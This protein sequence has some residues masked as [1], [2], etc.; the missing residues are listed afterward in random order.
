MS[1]CVSSSTIQHLPSQFAQNRGIQ[2]KLTSDTVPP[3]SIPPTYEL[4]FGAM[5]SPN[6]VG[7]YL[8]VVVKL[9][10][11]LFFAQFPRPDLLLFFACPPLFV[12][13]YKW[14]TQRTVQ[15]P[16]HTDE[17]NYTKL[18]ATRVVN[19]SPYKSL[20]LWSSKDNGPKFR[21]PGQKNK[22]QPTYRLDQVVA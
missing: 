7:K 18:P 8:H 1:M 3:L 4:I 9:S 16:V 20:S 22:S 5:K 13:T 21:L 17:W 19:S 10:G 14:T 15:N 6:N 12:P 2:T 11:S